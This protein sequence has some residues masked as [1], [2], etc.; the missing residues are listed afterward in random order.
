MNSGQITNTNGQIS[1]IGGDASVNA[2]SLQGGTVQ[3]LRTFDLTWAAS[4]T[5]ISMNGHAGDSVTLGSGN[6]VIINH[7]DDLRVNGDLT[8]TTLTGL[9]NGSQANIIGNL[10]GTV[11]SI[12]TLN[13]GGELNHNGTFTGVKTLTVGG[14]ATFNDSVTGTGLGSNYQIGGI[15]SG[16]T[17]ITNVDTLSADTIRNN[18]EITGTGA[19]SR[20]M[21]RVLEGAAAGGNH[22]GNVSNYQYVTIGSTLSNEGDITG[23][24][25]LS[26]LQINGD[27]NNLQVGNIED[28]GSLTANNVT[29][30][31]TISNIEKA[32]IEGDLQNSGDMTAVA[33]ADITGDLNN[34]G[35]IV[36]TGAGSVYNVDG[37]VTNFNEGQDNPG[38]IMN[39][40]SLRVNNNLTNGGTI[41][42]L[43]N[44]GEAI[45][46]GELINGQDAAG[47]DFE[48]SISGYERMTVDGGVF[49][50]S[51]GS[52]IGTG[53]GSVYSFTNIVDENALSNEGGI[54]NVESLINTG[55]VTNTGTISAT[56]EINSSLGE[57]PYSSFVVN[58]DLSNGLANVDPLTEWTAEN[59][60][61]PGEDL[62]E[63]H[64]TEFSAKMSIRETLPDNT[65]YIVNYSNMDVSGTVTNEINGY[66]QATGNGSTYRF[67][68]FDNAG[69]LT[70]VDKLRIGSDDEGNLLNRANGLIQGTGKG[71]IMN[72]SGDLTNSYGATI[73]NFETV[74]VRGDLTNEGSLEFIND[75]FVGGDFVNTYQNSGGPEN[76][77]GGVLITDTYDGRV[78]KLTV[79]G[80]AEINGGQLWIGGSGEQLVVGKDYNVITVNDGHLTVN[81]AL[82]VRALNEYDFDTLLD[83]NYAT[84]SSNQSAP[85]TPRLFHAEGFYTD[86]DYWVSLRRDYVY[87]KPALTKNQKNLGTYLD[88]IAYTLNSAS[89]TYTEGDLFNVLSSLDN[90]N[91]KGG[92]VPSADYGYTAGSDD[93]YTYAAPM[94]TNNGITA[95]ALDA[96]D[97]M[98]GSIYADMTMMSMQNSWL[99]HQHLGNFLRPNPCLTDYCD[100]G[101][102]EECSEGEKCKQSALA[103]NVCCPE[104]GFGF[105]KNAWAMA[106]GNTGNVE[107]DGNAL[108]F[109]F[110]TA[111]LIVG[112]D[113]YRSCTGRAGV[114]FS[115]GSSNLDKDSTRMQKADIDNYQVGLYGMHDFCLGH[116]IGTVGIGLDGYRTSR[117]LQFGQIGRNSNYVDRLHHGET[118]S[119]Q[120]SLR[121]EQSWDWCC[122]RTLI[123]PFV[124]LG[125]THMA[126]DGMQEWT[127][128]GDR[129][130]GQY[131][132]ELNH[133]DYELDSMRSEIGIRLS[134]CLYRCN[135]S[136][137]LNMNASWIHEYADTNATLTNSFTNRN[138]DV[139]TTGYG[140][141]YNTVTNDAFNS[142]QYNVCSYKVSG[143]NLDRDYA[144][145]GLGMSWTNPCRVMSVFCSYDL[146]ANGQEKLHNGT[147]GVELDW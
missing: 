93:N 45:I 27:L 95:G 90:E 56:E 23:T 58:G 88:K 124:G 42:V 79:Q 145:L 49:N 91:I 38:V 46:G 92:N 137:H 89:D 7:F 133:S 47:N 113:I 118:E 29:N 97:Q 24:G 2:T 101:T 94:Y 109:D 96:L 14:D 142:N 98:T 84:G 127:E 52:I 5:T 110:D 106:Y 59:I 64:R 73:R 135:R 32:D 6:N 68:A 51:Q 120:F 54:F 26:E 107:S 129:E 41:D 122:F 131:V 10:S 116:L 111:G 60:A 36:S 130:N 30:T 125:Y 12:E 70:E 78:G 114:F 102:D 126:V 16:F 19:G 140:N 119:S 115:F 83:D 86:T 69:V 134:R 55:N 81:E 136:L 53:K 74:N 65:S 3:N 11:N 103:N 61:T 21:A 43:D 13:I 132:T 80:D 104:V 15:L 121:V 72:V 50:R 144:W 18:A 1:G 87:G 35:L 105:F 57:G 4:D 141:A 138:H 99:L 67:G 37:S 20:L 77:I 85:A 143:V 147:F 25:N 62:R 28:F 8:E 71:S 139:E 123:Q 40:A 63:E 44:N 31:G 17:G 66:I 108:G 39:V 112:G 33:K 9:G 82:Q 76:A 117:H 48:A 22:T 75:A 146:L 100:C 128:W 34:T